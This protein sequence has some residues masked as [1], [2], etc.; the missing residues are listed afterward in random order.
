MGSSFIYDKII[1]IPAIL[2]AFSFHEYAHAKVADMLGD[3][4]PRF[5]G[6]LTLNPASHIDPLGALMIILC[7]FGWAKPVQTNP[8]VYKNYYK[9]DLK[10]SIAGPL[11]NLIVG[12]VGC[13]LFLLL[14]KVQYRTGL[15]SVTVYSVIID[16]VRAIFTL[17]I[18]L[19][20][21]NLLPLPGLDGFAVLR[22]LKPDFFYRISETLNRYQYIIMV[23]ILL[24]GGRIIQMPVQFIINIIWNIAIAIVGI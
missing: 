22:D 11:A 14:I 21:F 24:A 1:L 18:S 3:K 17:N 6:R 9:D 20:V 23:V 2:I 16:I 10:V 4:T 8:N 5:Q 13:F 19:F 15:K 7:G 12:I